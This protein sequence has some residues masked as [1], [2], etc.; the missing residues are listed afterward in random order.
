[1]L[2]N[3]IYNHIAKELF[4]TFFAILF[5]FT[6][7]AW[8]VRAVNYLN[9]II[10]DAHSVQTY[11]IYSF[12]NI[13]NIV[14]KFIPISFL[15]SLIMTIYRFKTQKEFLIL[16]CAG[17]SK[18][19]IIN[20]FVFIAVVTIIFNLMLSALVTPSALNYSR[21]ILKTSNLDQ[22]GSAIK[23]NDFTDTFKNVTFF[24][25]KKNQ[26]NEFFNIFIKDDSNSIKDLMNM[27]DSDGKTIVAER[28]FI[29]NGQ[30]ILFNGLMHSSNNNKISS[31]S[32]KKTSIS[33]SSLSNRTIQQ[34][35]LRETK[36]L[37]LINCLRK[38]YS[39]S[40][41]GSCSLQE[42]GTEVI[43]NISRRVSMPLYIL[44]IVLIACFSIFSK[45][46]K[47]NN[48]LKKYFIFIFSF[49]II[50]FSELLIRYSGKSIIHALS[51][52]LFPIVCSPILYMLLVYKSFKEKLS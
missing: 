31:I 37:T 44:L 21:D 12:L 6:I 45:N 38:N 15:V 34:P 14:T 36:T 5:T 48:F 24:V 1:M 13:T 18:F 22:I 17:I 26:N 4:G 32:F 51:Y 23:Q 41:Q 28:G 2:R 29:D 49:L 35:K 50:V 19:K 3:K 47:D 8:T 20:L 9:L 43:E 46:E 30:L 33:L 27:K 7:I 10:D 25:E 42:L 39:F 40:Y 11:F 52:F 16:W